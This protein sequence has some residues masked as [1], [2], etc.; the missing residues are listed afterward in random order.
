MRQRVSEQSHP[1]RGIRT[2]D[3]QVSSCLHLLEILVVKRSLLLCDSRLLCLCLG[4][5]GCGDLWEK[6]VSRDQAIKLEKQLDLKKTKLIIQEQI[7]PLGI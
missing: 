2:G 5:L 7:K 6:R 3:L 1:V 4:L